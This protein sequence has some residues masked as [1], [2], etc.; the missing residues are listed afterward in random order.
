MGYSTLIDILGSI[1]IGGLLFLILIRMN[2]AATKNTYTYSGEL[3]VQEN[4]VAVVEVIE[5]DFRKIGYCQDWTKIPDPSKA[6]LSA[7][8]SD[9]TFITDMP[10]PPSY[11]H[12]DGTVDTLRYYIGSTS[13][14]ANT[15]N[16][17]DRLLYRQLNSGVP[18]ASNVGTTQFRIHY[19]DVFGN[20][21]STPISSPG[22]ISTMQ[23]NVTVEN[24][25]AYDEEYSTAFWRQIRLAAR[26][27]RNR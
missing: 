1:V 17:R 18:L 16:P 4:L 9:I 10:N 26:N 19:F 24:T 5:H 25:A 13:E 11:P 7:D 27:L 6:I 22:E 12:G 8:T 20:E 23:I 2:D 3:L 15:P 21:L 14:L